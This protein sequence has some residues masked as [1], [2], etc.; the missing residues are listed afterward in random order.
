MV[1]MFQSEEMAATKLRALYQRTKGRDLLDIWL[2]T[3]EVGINPDLVCHAFS[4]YRPE[5]FT[6]KKA[7]LNLENKLT[8]NLFLTD[9]GN[10]TSYQFNNYNIEIAAEQIIDLY[11]SNL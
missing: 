10:L 8:D 4:T 6:A 9:I 3:N 5:G 1:K 2:M 7:I 11:L